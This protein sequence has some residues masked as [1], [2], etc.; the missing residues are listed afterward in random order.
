MND[1]ETSLKK[2]KA[3]LDQRWA[4]LQEKQGEILAA[5]QKTWSEENDLLDEVLQLVYDQLVYLRMIHYQ[6]LIPPKEEPTRCIEL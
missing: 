3:D 4:A 5:F 1:T 2:M 6:K